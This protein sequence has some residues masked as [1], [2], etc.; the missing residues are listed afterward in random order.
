MEWVTISRQFNA[1]HA[2]LIRSRLEASGIEAC[3]QGELASFSIAGYA[4]ASGGIRIQ[5]L[6]GKIEAAKTLIESIERSD[7]LS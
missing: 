2:H 5:V 1:A 4:L 7:E 3:I 6:S